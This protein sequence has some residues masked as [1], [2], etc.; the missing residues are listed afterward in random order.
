MSH[1]QVQDILPHEAGRKKYHF[2]DP[3]PYAKH[4]TEYVPISLTK[5]FLLHI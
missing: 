3:S 1:G 2:K 4:V 5:Q